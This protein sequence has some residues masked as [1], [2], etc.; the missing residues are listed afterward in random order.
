M[1]RCPFQLT[2]CPQ[3]GFGTQLKIEKIS[4]DKQ[5]GT[6]ELGSK[7][8]QGRNKNKAGHTVASS[9]AEPEMQIRARTEKDRIAQNRQFRSSQDKNNYDN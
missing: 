1:S 2:R 7:K 9:K 5:L 3:P 4:P 6:W 8:R